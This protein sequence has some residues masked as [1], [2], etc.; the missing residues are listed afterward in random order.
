MTSPNPEAQ[1]GTDE[2]GQS[3]GTPEGQGTGENGG[4]GQS[5]GE[6]ATSSETVSKADHEKALERMRAAD[7][8]ASETEAKLKQ[9][10][11]KD[12]PEQEKLKGRLAELE[13]E[14]EKDREALKDARLEL[15][16]FKDG[17]KFKWKNPATALKLADLSNVEIDADGTVRNLTSALEALAKSDPYLLDTDSKEE[18]GPKGST[19]APSN[20]GK[21]PSSGS[22]VGQ[23][24]SRI[25]A[26]RTRI[27][28]PS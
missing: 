9:L 23:M 15:A 4:A 8:R 3:A 20:A 14:R 18:D 7:R 2:T 26:L 22:V 17:G 12:L 19:G 1:S 13:A 10:L 27:G 25:P 11:E 5:A 6:T 21:P 16:F 28:K 24:A